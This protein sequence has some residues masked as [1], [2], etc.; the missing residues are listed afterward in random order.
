MLLD[1]IIEQ[2]QSER[3]VRLPEDNA[4]ELF[5]CEQVLRDYD[6]SSD[7]IETGIVGGGNDGAIDGVY[8]FLDGNLLAADSEIFDDDFAPS[9]MSA[10][11]PLLLILVQAKRSESF[12]ETA[13]DLAARQLGVFSI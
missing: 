6:V 2:R 7:E 1:Q 5:A 11:V 8:A 10:G 12:T 3:E 9:R 4:F 13:L